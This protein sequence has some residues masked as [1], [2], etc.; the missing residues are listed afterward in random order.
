MS[1]VYKLKD[2]ICRVCTR[3]IRF[4]SEYRERELMGHKR[5]VLKYRAIHIG[6]P[7]DLEAATP[8]PTSKY[9]LRRQLEESCAA[10]NEAQ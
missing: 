4:V 10:R 2:E 3:P 6:E 5:R 1:R 9:Q 7:T 8:R